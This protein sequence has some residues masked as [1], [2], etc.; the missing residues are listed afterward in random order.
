MQLN[1]RTSLLLSEGSIFVRLQLL[2]QFDDVQDVVVGMQLVDS[3]KTR[4]LTAT[5]RA[6]ND[7]VAN[8]FLHVKHFKMHLYNTEGLR[9]IENLEALYANCV[10]TRQLFW[11]CTLI[12]VIRVADT[13]F[14]VIFSLVFLYYTRHS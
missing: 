12:I 3:V 9:K 4:V 6:N 14:D 5:H 11:F 1:E 8:N 13:A 2:F 7:S 10:R